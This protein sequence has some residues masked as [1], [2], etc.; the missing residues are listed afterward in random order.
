MH[1]LLALI[2]FAG[3]GRIGFDVASQPSDG[4]TDSSGDGMLIGHDEDGDGVPDSIDVC[5]QVSDLQDDADGDGV[6]DFCDPKINTPGDRIA[7]FSSMAPGDQPF[8]LSTFTTGAWTHSSDG[9]KLDGDL[10]ADF[11]AGL[12][13][14]ISAGDVRVDIGFDITAV[15]SGLQHQFALGTTTRTPAYFAELNEQIGNY[16]GAYITY[17]DGS[18]YNQVDSRPLVLGIHPARVRFL[19]DERVNTSVR[20]NIQ[21]DAEG[22]APMVSD[23]TY[24][25]SDLLQLNINNLQLE[26]RYVCVITSP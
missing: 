15:G 2:A 6:G 19:L 23:N 24:Q 12:T 10:G 22:Y 4:R 8:T 13:L 25:S 14:P 16:S 7:V 18:T 1:R 5:P 3:C 9:F 26:I 17:F 11:F 20:A 21:I